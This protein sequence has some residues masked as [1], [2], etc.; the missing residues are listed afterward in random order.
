MH[1][2]YIFYISHPIACTPMGCPEGRR[3]CPFSHDVDVVGAA[4][5]QQGVNRCSNALDRAGARLAQLQEQAQAAEAA[6]TAA[7]EENTR[8]QRQD[9]G[10][11]VEAKAMPRCTKAW[12]RDQGQAL[13]PTMAARGSVG[14]QLS[15]HQLP[16]TPPAS[17]EPP[18]KK[19]CPW[20]Q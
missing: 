19:P 8:R 12:R 4:A 18:K 10:E 13:Q 1:V 14:R 9:G 17:P 6:G 7:I 11:I 5:R 15:Q 16:R 2:Q 3:Q 20:R